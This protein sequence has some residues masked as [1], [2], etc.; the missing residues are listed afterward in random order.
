MATSN[1]NT[2]SMFSKSNYM[3]MLIGAV[4]MALGM[5]LMSGGK[6][7]DPHVFDKNAVYSATR[8]TVAPILIFIG[9]AIEIYAIFK[10]SS[11]EKN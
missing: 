1:S 3:W 9:L 4:V 6:S 7:D 8:I 11:T 5:F 2:P 10:K